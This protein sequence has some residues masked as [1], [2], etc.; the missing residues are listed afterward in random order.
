[1]AIANRGEEAPI[2]AGADDVPPLVLREESGIPERVLARQVL[3]R[4]ERQQLTVE[5]GL[6]LVRP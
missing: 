5:H 4:L 2:R 6:R 1:M 3:P